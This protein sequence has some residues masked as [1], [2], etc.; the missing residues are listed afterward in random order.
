MFST[1]VSVGGIFAKAHVVAWRDVSNGAC[2]YAIWYATE[3]QRSGV[4]VA[5]YVC[6]PF[7][8]SES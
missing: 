2:K 7:D 6:K 4:N 8:K 1:T 3:A 5:F